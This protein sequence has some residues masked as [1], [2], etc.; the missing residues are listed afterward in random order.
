MAGGNK[1]KPLA[2]Q[3]ENAGIGAVAKLTIHLPLRPVQTAAGGK[4][5]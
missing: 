1:V 2:G 3:A 5:K 4:M